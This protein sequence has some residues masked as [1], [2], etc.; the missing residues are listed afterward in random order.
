MSATRSALLLIGAVAV[1]IGLIWIGQGLGWFRYPARSFMIDQTRWAWR[2]LALVGV[3]LLSA[4][5]AWRRR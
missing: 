1:A 2:G 5:F 3:G 4:A